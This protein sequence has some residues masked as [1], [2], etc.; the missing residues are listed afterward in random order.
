MARIP[1]NPD[2]GP[3]DVKPTM[4]PPAVFSPNGCG[5]NAPVEYGKAAEY[6]EKAKNTKTE[7]KQDSAQQ[8]SQTQSSVQQSSQTQSSV[9]Q[10]SET[11]SSVQQSSETQ[12]AE[13]ESSQ[14]SEKS[15]AESD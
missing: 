1:A 9:E 4:K 10:S 3:T 12:S 5:S 2:F 15:S 13:S 7:P 6:L 14:Q 11:Q 8:S